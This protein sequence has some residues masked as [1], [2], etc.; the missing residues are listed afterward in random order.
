MDARVGDYRIEILMEHPVGDDWQILQ[1]DLVEI[2]LADTMLTIQ[3][4]IKGRV[5][6]G[7]S[8]E[9]VKGGVRRHGNYWANF[10]GCRKLFRRRENKLYRKL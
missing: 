5:F 7:K 4:S 9:I 2:C 8:Q 6:P 3:G 1:V 10:R